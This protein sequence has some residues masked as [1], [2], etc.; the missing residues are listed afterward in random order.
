MTRSG[1]KPNSIDMREATALFGGAEEP[2]LIISRSLKLYW[3]LAKDRTLGKS[4]DLIR[5]WKNPRK[6]A[7][8]NLVQVIGDK[9]IDQITGDD[10]PDFRNWWIECLEVKDLTPNSFNAV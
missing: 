9:S 3:T 5:R 1:D 6:K 2:S 10:M 4:P 8:Q 7:I